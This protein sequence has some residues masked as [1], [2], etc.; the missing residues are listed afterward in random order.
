VI[1]RA[2]RHG[3]TLRDGI[4]F[5]RYEVTAR[6]GSRA[7]LH[8]PGGRVLNVIQEVGETVPPPDGCELLLA[9]RLDGRV[10]WALHREGTVWG[11][12]LGHGPGVS[13]V[14]L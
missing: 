6:N 13:G 11:G 1:G 2:T 8:I 14:E 10:G 4:I 3:G 12:F 5:T 9:T 7:S